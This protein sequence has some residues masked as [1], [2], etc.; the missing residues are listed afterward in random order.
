MLSSKSLRIIA[1]VATVACHAEVALAASHYSI[2][3]NYSI[4]INPSGPWSYI[5][6]N[7]LLNVKTKSEFGI[8]NYWNWGNGGNA[9]WCTASAISRNKTGQT[10]NYGTIVQPTNYLRLDPESNTFNAVRF[11]A[12]SS[13]TFVVKG[14]FLGIDVG[15]NSHAVAI[16]VNGVPTFGTTINSYGQLAR[17]NLNLTLA[18]GDTVDFIVETGPSCFDLSTGLTATISGP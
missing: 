2:T 13:G 7:G 18:M 17:F 9:G 4:K 10:L 14:S 11:S 6:E 15:E 16:D 3:P 8:N 1:L 12:P 5:D